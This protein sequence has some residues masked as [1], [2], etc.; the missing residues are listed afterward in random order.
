MATLK[1][2]LISTLQSAVEENAT[3]QLKNELRSIITR[4]YTD[5]GTLNEV[6]QIYG[7]A[8]IPTPPST[9]TSY[10]VYTPDFGVKKKSKPLRKQV[11]A[12]KEVKPKPSHDDLTPDQITKAIQEDKI[13][14]IF[15]SI[16]A[17]RKFTEDRFGVDYGRKTSKNSV[18][19]HFLEQIEEVEVDDLEGEI[20]DTEDPFKD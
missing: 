8:S 1:Q 7:Y 19:N 15:G 11:V 2:N 14:Q 9:P 17:F 12:D 5:I 16:E 6:N 20:D 10:K 4:N 3:S 13:E 18:L